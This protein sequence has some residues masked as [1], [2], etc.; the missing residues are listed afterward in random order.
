MTLQPILSEFSHIW[1][2]FYFL[3]YQCTY[4][5]IYKTTPQFNSI[6]LSAQPIGPLNPADYI[7]SRGEG[8]TPPP[9]PHHV[10]YTHMVLFTYCSLLTPLPNAKEM[11]L[12]SC[13][14]MLH[15]HVDYVVLCSSRAHELQIWCSSHIHALQTMQRDN[16]IPMCYRHGPHF[17]KNNQIYC[18][19]YPTVQL[20][21]LVEEEYACVSFLPKH[22]RHKHTIIVFTSHFF[23]VCYR[24]GSNF[25]HAQ[26]LHS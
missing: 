16:H 22:A 5:E 12:M 3:F 25:M 18:T 14:H 10:L 20:L 26:E 2:K 7:F 4:R 17:P 19:H 9:P 23:F 15:I 13:L 24:H 1:G 8:L 6:M 21:W 11:V